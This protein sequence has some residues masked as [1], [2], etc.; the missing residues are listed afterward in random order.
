MTIYLYV[1]QH[2][3][4]GLKYFGMTR[5]PNPH[6]YMGSGLH[7]R[8]HITKHGKEYVK[9]IEL[10]GF[11]DQEMCTGFALTFSKNNNI[12][13][14]E[15]WANMCAETGLW[16]GGCFGLK[17]SEETKQKISKS[18]KGRI[19][20][21][22]TKQKL[23]KAST[24][25]IKSKEECVKISNAR[26]GKE[27]YLKGK[28]KFDTV[29]LMNSSTKLKG[30]KSPAKD[31]MWINDGKI[32]KMIETQK[33]IPKDFTRG[34]LKES[35]N[36]DFIIINDGKNTRHNPSTKTIPVGW[37]RGSLRDQSGELN[38]SYGKI[39]INDGTI[40]KYISKNEQMPNGF[41]KGRLARKN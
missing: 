12:V 2:S 38:P 41:K 26:K 6:K 13:E 39:W 19:I 28:T 29:S 31:T 14:S 25:R 10:W 3:V 24:G 17:H 15:E 23:K 1:K 34:R 16:Y 20:N 27:S 30:R 37:K 7:W 18:G 33:N 22:E 5:K 9:T 4:T 40:N 35:T 21:E 8:R 11:D 36:R 32:E